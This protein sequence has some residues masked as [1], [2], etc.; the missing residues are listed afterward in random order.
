[1][2]QIIL[3]KDFT[4]GDLSSRQSARELS[5]KILPDADVVILDFNGIEFMSRSYADELFNVVS[6]LK[7]YE[8]VNPCDEVKTMIE[9]VFRKR[10]EDKENGVT[11]PKMYRFNNIEELSAFLTAEP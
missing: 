4:L 2:K 3:F 8:V 10:L 11:S 9:T 6:A 5:E 1:M 7:Q